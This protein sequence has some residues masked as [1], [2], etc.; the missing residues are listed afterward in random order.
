MSTKAKLTKKKKAQAKTP[1]S[2]I[3]GLAVVGL[4][5]L[6]AFD[7]TN[8][9]DAQSYIYFGLIGAALGAKIDD[10]KTWFGGGK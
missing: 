8:V 6:A 9:N 7:L 5:G 3:S 4:V 2:F 1:A 10:I